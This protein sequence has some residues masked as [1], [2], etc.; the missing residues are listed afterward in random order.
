MLGW[1]RRH[2][3]LDLILVLPDGSRTLI[4]AAWTDLDPSKPVGRQLDLP[5]T[6]TRVAA[7]SGSAAGVVDHYE[8]QQLVALCGESVFL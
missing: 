2:C 8:H 3:K 1:M 4:P 6:R 5:P 7:L